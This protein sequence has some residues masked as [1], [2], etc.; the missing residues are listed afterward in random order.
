M[1]SN[2]LIWGAGHNLHLVLN[3]IDY[4]SV[5]VCAIIDNNPQKCGDRVEGYRLITPD[6]I[7]E[8]SYDCI[9]IT[10]YEYETIICKCEALGIPQEKIRVFCQDK[11]TDS[12]FK[13]LYRII[14]D[15][16]REKEVMAYR[17]DSAPYEWGVIKTPRIIE[18]ERLLERVINERISLVRFGDGEFEIIRGKNRPRFQKCDEDLGLRLKT[19][20]QSKREKIIIA[21]SQNF[22]LNSYTDE[23]ADGIREYMYGE[24]RRD[25]LSMLDD[26]EYYDAY[27]TRPYLIYK[28]KNHAKFIFDLFFDVFMDRDIILVEGEWARIGINNDLFSTARSVRRILCPSRDAWSFYEKIK[29][30]VC[31]HS[32]KEDLVLVSLGPTA[33]VLCYDLAL[34]GYQALDIGQIDNEYEW[35][36]MSVTKRELISGKMVCELPDDQQLLDLKN[37]EYEKQIVGRVGVSLI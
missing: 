15:L 28:D 18:S 31:D 16:I 2:C 26:R 10:P 11:N 24:T 9:I 23:A 35:W 30:C 21:I 36:K 3:A 1:K 8:Y 27:A 25:I 14:D 4:D 20:L 29:T 37:P 5:E 32:R 19:I 34:M 17:L 12:V 22:N 13:P 6:R 33:T 7:G